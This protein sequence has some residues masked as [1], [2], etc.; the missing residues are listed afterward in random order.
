[1]YFFKMFYEVNECR[2][3]EIFENLDLDF[4]DDVIE[5]EIFG[6]IIT[7]LSKLLSL[8]SIFIVVNKID[9]FIV[10]SIVVIFV[11]LNVLD[12]SVYFRSLF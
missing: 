6:V 9:I 10:F 12:I 5:F 8:V 11:V 2:K 7:K 4:D 1:M 3:I